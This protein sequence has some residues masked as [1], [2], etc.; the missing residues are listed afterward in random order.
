[1]GRPKVNLWE[2]PMTEVTRI[3]NRI[4]SGDPSAADPLLPLVY[5]KLRQ[6]AA[7]KLARE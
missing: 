4:E 2:R 6:L 1:M 3:L 7:A 5:R